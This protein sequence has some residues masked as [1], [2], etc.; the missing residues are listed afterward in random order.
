MIEIR[1]NLAKFDTFAKLFCDKSVKFAPIFVLP[2]LLAKFD[3][4]FICIL[5][6]F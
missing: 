1:I 2:N 4:N 3:A 5:H 6:T